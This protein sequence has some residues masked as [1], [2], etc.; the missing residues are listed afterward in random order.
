LKIVIAHNRYQILGGEDSVVNNELELLRRSGHEVELYERNNDHIV[1]VYEKVS[2]AINVNYSKKSKKDFKQFLLEVMPDIVHVHNFFPALTPSIYDACMELSIPVIQTIHNYRISCAA[3]TFLRQGQVCEKCMLGSPYN[4]VRYKCYKDSR[5]GSLAVARMIDV[6]RKNNTWNKK[7][8]FFIALTKFS[9]KKVVEIGVDKEKILI[10]PNFVHKGDCSEIEFKDRNE[11][12]FVGRISEDKGINIILTAWKKLD[13]PL[14]MIG[15]GPLLN[16]V[17]EENN[18]N[19]L[20]LGQLSKN[21]VA[22]HIK[23]A[24]F[25]I[26]ASTWYEG[27]PMVLV[28]AMRAGIPVIV[29]KLGSMMEI[30]SEF[31][32][33]LHFVPGNSLELAEKVETLYGNPKLCEEMGSKARQEYLNRYTPEANYLMLM[34]IYGKAID[35]VRSA[36]LR[37]VGEQ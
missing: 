17:V 11:V 2:V 34:Y 1:S 9:K 5:I 8:S 10:K 32:T 3:A 14:T 33:G 29:P 22:A 25:L 30:V 6:H 24:R 36:K 28:E 7:V 37:S 27:F 12:V 4:A 19:I 15:S 26:M 31:E 21:D 16:D 18:P 35:S 20:A 23:K 13:I